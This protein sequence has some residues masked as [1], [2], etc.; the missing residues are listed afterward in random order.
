MGKPSFGLQKPAVSKVAF[1]SENSRVPIN[2]VIIVG[3]ER[4]VWVIYK[5][6]IGDPSRLLLRNLEPQRLGE[7]F[8]LVVIFYRRLLVELDF[9]RLF[10]DRDFRIGHFR[11]YVPARLVAIIVRCRSCN[12]THP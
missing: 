1:V 11:H 9:R 3:S 7:K 6:L 2:P 5:L 8:L 10:C 12:G 4:K